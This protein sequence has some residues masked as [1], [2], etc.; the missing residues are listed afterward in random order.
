MFPVLSCNIFAGKA[1]KISLVMSVKNEFDNKMFGHFDTIIFNKPKIQ[2]VSVKFI[3]TL[4]FLTIIPFVTYM[5]HNLFAD[6]VSIFIVSSMD[7]IAFS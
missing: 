3:F 6:S 2:N 7:C 1:W 4:T 5:D